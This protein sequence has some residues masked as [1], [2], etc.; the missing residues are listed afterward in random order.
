MFFQEVAT[1]LNEHF[2]LKTVISTATHL[3]DE[4]DSENEYENFD[5]E[6]SLD[7]LRAL[8]C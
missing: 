1:S 8:Y 5:I 6:R 3:T 7:Y 2:R 4:P